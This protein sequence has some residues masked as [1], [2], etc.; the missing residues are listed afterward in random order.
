MTD[1][2]D[3]PGTGGDEAGADDGATGDVTAGED[4]GRTA[5]GERPDVPDWEDE[6]FDRVADRLMYHYDL[7][8]DRRARGERFPLYGR[9]EMHT[10]KHFLH[11]AL[12]YAH[13]ETTEH[14]FATR[15]DA[16]GV[17][18]VER[19]VELGHELAE[20]WIDADEEHYGT[21][22]TFVLVTAELP[23]EV[24]SFVSGFKDRSLLKLGY[25]GHYEVNLVVVAPRTEEIVASES[26]DVRRAF[27][28]WESPEEESTGLLGRLLP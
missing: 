3:A 2:G 27:A 5:G 6:Y 26:A 25:H 24:R 20:A 15:V 13:H 16:V 12:S 18:D 14:L 8:K 10:Q 9:M 4:G 21:D 17:A 19:Y 23:G 28:L 1:A 7:E 22:F 11:P